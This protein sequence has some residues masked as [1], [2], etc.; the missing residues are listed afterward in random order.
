MSLRPSRIPCGTA[1]HH[2]G[3]PG[4]SLPM[5]LGIRRAG[6]LL[7]AC[8]VGDRRDCLAERAVG[9]ERAW[10]DRGRCFVGGRSV[11]EAAQ[12]QD[13]PQRSP[14]RCRPASPRA[15]I[16]VCKLVAELYIFKVP[17]GSTGLRRFWSLP[18]LQEFL[19]GPG[20]SSKWICNSFEKFVGA[21]RC[22][23]CMIVTTPPSSST[24]Y[25]ISNGRL[26][27]STPWP[28]E[29]KVVMGDLSALL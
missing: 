5:L 15:R 19:L 21:V 23:F 28:L 11:V 22:P 9:L 2:W 14:T 8:R 26:L 20:S 10:P 6:R 27:A 7:G 4:R 1:S 18:R 3:D 12:D 13:L 16:R 25:R 29:Q 24:P 17:Q